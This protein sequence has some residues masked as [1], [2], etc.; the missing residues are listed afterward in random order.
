M[1][2]DNATPLVQLQTVQA[3]IPPD[4]MLLYVAQASYEPGTSPLST[5][6]PLRAYQT[7]E[8]Q[9][10]SGPSIAESPLDM[11]ERYVQSQL[12]VCHIGADRFDRSD[13]LV[14][15]RLALGVHSLPAVPEVE[16]ES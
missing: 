9:E 8:E 4:G 6:I 1:E 2:L 10:Q 3:Q 5:W 16:M 14:R 7:R 12:A 11:F 15:R 13:R